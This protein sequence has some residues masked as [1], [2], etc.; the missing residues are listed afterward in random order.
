M[1]IAIGLWGTTPANADGNIYAMASGNVAATDN[2]F[3][4]ASS[5]GPQSDVYF[6]LRPGVVA[7]YDTPRM[8]QELVAEVEI[9]E[10]VVHSDKPS[11]TV[12]G[13]WKGFFTPGPRSEVVLGANGGTG[14]LNA[15]AARTSPD[16]TQIMVTPAGPTELRQADASEFLSWQSTKETR[17][18]QT[19]FVRWVA[20]SDGLAMP[21]T[22]DSVE[23]GLSLG[24]ERLFQHDTLGIDIGGS[25][26]RLELIAPMGAVPGSRLDRQINPRA[27]AIWRHD[28]SKMWSTSLDGGVIYVN[29]VG[30]DPYDPTATDNRAAPFPIFGGFIAYTDVW[31]RAMLDLHQSVAPELFIA[32]NTLN[33][34]AL[35]QLA[36]PLPWL[37]ANPHERNPKL[38]ALASVGVER[39]QLI[40]P[41][42]GDP[43]GEFKLAHADIGVTW[44]PR[45]GQT[46]GLRYELVDQKGDSVAAMVTPSFV[47]STVFFTFAIQYPDRLSSQVPRRTQ[48]VR[49]D[50]SDLSPIGAEPVVPDAAEPE[51]VP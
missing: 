49:S 39:T 44:T 30:V 8:V 4:V 27:T 22:T 3:A 20:T 42:T 21:T 34:R 5:A 15:I 45:P 12:L 2:A 37:D 36:L 40:D 10:Y 9:L 47:R 11:V 26:L 50:R 1:V 16:Q 35:L 41:V 38:V 48:S 28:L 43:L 24:F 7:A 6:Q 25:F 29:P 18:S 23:A 17:T 32:Q 19:A 14:Q 13:G 46:Y 51:P 33:D 31:G